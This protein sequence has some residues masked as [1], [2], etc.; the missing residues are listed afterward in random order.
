M[1]LLPNIN[2]QTGETEITNVIFTNRN[3]N[4][5]CGHTVSLQDPFTLDDHLIKN[6]FVVDKRSHTL[7][8]STLEHNLWRAVRS[9][10]YKNPVQWN[11]NYKISASITLNDIAIIIKSSTIEL[12]VDFFMLDLIFRKRLKEF[13]EQVEIERSTHDGVIITSGNEINGVKV[14]ECGRESVVTHDYN[15]ADFYFDIKYQCNML[16]MNLN[17]STN[18][19]HRLYK[20]GRYYTDLARMTSSVWSN[21]NYEPVQRFAEPYQNYER[22]FYPVSPVNLNTTED[23]LSINLLESLTQPDANS[24]L[25]VEEFSSTRPCVKEKYKQYIH[26]QLYKPVFKKYFKENE[27]PNTTLLLGAEIE[28]DCGGE[29]ELHARECLK[30]ICGESDNIP[31]ETKMYCSHDESL[32]AGIEFTTMPCSLQY[33]KEEMQYEKMFKYLDRNGY[34]AH[35]TDTCGLHIHANRTYL[36][37]TNLQQ[38]LVIIKIIYIL[39]KFNE[40]VC[41]IARK[42]DTYSKFSGTNDIDS[43]Y[44]LYGCYNGQKYVALN[45]K[46]ED[47]IE[48]RCFKGTLKYKTFILTLEFVSKI[49][50]FSKSINI[51]EL[52]SIT[53]S[54]LFSTFS[55]ELKDYY[56]N[57]KQYLTTKEKKYQRK[58]KKHEL[59]KQI[60]HLQKLLRRSKNYME[61]KR[62]QQKIEQLN[63]KIKEVE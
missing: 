6:I 52:E 14:G 4:T 31:L 61:Q 3:G 50:D 54:D 40:E 18:L 11:P 12:F 48:F 5:C 58:I 13:F 43:I 7:L 59:Q 63:K 47:T 49:I 17:Y 24:V 62:L 60:T 22:E 45:L 15:I 21:R 44:E 33:H 39:E 2:I 34:K 27:N 26:S 9:R 35:D 38:Q 56:N 32:K 20:Q 36:G 23:F 1:L 29:T 16:R 19:L 55:N 51:E 25:S 46:H 42:N 8:S 10:V 37:N 57:R 41:V 28:V 30:I 53:W